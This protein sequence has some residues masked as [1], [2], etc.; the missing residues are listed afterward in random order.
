MVPLLLA[1]AITLSFSHQPIDALRAVVDRAGAVAIYRATVCNHRPESAALAGG[2]ILQAAEGNGISVLDPDLIRLTVQR[3]RNT[4]AVQLAKGIE[5]TLPLA[6]VATSAVSSIP[7]WGK[8]VAPAILVVTQL[9]KG[10]IQQTETPLPGQWLRTD[11]LVSLTPGA[12]ASWLLFA[13]WDG[14]AKKPVMA[15]L[16]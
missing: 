5:V 11:T 10:K 14:Q 7:T 16:P 2:R 4:P 9:V 6:S 13:R 15:Q 8:L 12:C 3:Q 1:Q